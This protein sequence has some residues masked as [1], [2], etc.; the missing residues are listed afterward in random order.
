M[1]NFESLKYEHLL[2]MNNWC[3]VHIFKWLLVGKNYRICQ[4]E[5]VYLHSLCSIMQLFNW[6]I[7][8]SWM[9]AKFNSLLACEE[10]TQ[11]TSCKYKTII[12]YT[13][14]SW[15]VGLLL[16]NLTVLLNYIVFI[17]SAACLLLCLC[18][19]CRSSFFILESQFNFT[20][21]FLSPCWINNRWTRETL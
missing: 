4:L 14:R 12:L 9:L 7:E 15:L 16:R 13:S 1:E 10:H 2:K 20:G 8:K 11:S 5:V 6:H 3:S 21:T 17:D 18:D 19:Q